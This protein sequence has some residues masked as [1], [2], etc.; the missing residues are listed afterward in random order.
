MPKGEPIGSVVFDAVEQPN[1]ESIGETLEFHRFS[2]QH[3]I[4]NLDIYP[5]MK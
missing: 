5:F 2:N 3:V 1:S 4:P